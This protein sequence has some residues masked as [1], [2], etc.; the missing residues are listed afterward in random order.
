MTVKRHLFDFSGTSI[1]SV[2]A[3]LCDAVIYAALLLTFVSAEAFTLGMAAA[4]G[5]LAGGL[6]HYSLCRFW[7]FRRFEA[8]ILESLALYF[9]MSWMA[10]AGHGLLT[11]WFAGFLGALGGWLLSKTIL[12]V[13]W[14]YPLSRFVVFDRASSAED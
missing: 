5:A 14:T 6:I 2:L 4:I 10:A 12:W 8:P 9:A 11:E 3:T 13:L 1:A 7:V